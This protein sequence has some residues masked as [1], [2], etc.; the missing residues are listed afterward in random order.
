M[1]RHKSK[2][3]P[4]L[5]RWLQSLQQHEKSFGKEDIFLSNE[6]W[7]ELYKTYFKHREPLHHCTTLK[8]FSYYM[9]SIS[10]DRTIDGF[11]RKVIRNPKYVICYQLNKHVLQE[12]NEDHSVEQPGTC[13]NVHTMS[14]IQS[15]SK[16]SVMPYSI[17]PKTL[18][19]TKDF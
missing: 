12:L 19:L 4:N 2:L 17:V 3:K 14:S 5:I 15:P 10:Y 16:Y 7:F 18:S 6:G 11:S 13:N 9:S 1:A 8:Q